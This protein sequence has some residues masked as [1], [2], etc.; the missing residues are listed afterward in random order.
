MVGVDVPELLL[1]P[2]LIWGKLRRFFRRAE[3]LAGLPSCRP[4]VDEEDA[5]RGFW[6][7]L[8]LI[9]EDKMQD[10]KVKIDLW[11]EEKYTEH[12]LRKL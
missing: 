11:I 1:A 6:S 8:F 3:R 7:Y 10:V 4:D 2:E 5:E 9:P 12:E